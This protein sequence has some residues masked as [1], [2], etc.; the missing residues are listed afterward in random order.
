LILSLNAEDESVGRIVAAFDEAASR[1]SAAQLAPAI[2]VCGKSATSIFRY[3]SVGATAAVLQNA[4]DSRTRIPDLARRFNS[5]R[6]KWAGWKKNESSAP[7]LLF[8]PIDRVARG[9]L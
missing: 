5:R 4:R 2:L 7:P 3:G 9:G 1:M 8:R 6:A